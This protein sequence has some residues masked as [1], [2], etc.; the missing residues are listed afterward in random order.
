[1]TTLS[2][3]CLTTLT[4]RS[5]NVSLRPRPPLSKSRRQ[6]RRGASFTAPPETPRVHRPNLPRVT[7]GPPAR[8]LL[9]SKVEEYPRPT[10]RKV[11]MGSPRDVRPA[12]R[13]CPITG[14]Y[15]CTLPRMALAPMRPHVYSVVCNLAHMP[16]AGALTRMLR[17]THSPQPRSPILA[18]GRAR[19]RAD[20]ARWQLQHRLSLTHVH[21]AAHPVSAAPV[22]MLHGPRPR[23]GSRAVRG[24]PRVCYMYFCSTI[25]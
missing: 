7:L 17:E 23:V 5:G 12:L 6:T 15:H 24:M 1:M 13:L 2:R 25:S 4:D 14:V 18:R 8:S 21:S 11:L 3:T 19:A 16:T 10:T 22:C 20:E 9:R